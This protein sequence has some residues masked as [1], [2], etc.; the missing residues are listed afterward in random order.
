MKDW[1]ERSRA[2]SLT[3][4]EKRQFEEDGFLLLPNVVPQSRVAALVDVADRL[5]E[6]YRPQCGIG[7]NDIRPQGG[8]RPHDVLNLK[9]CATKDPAFL[10]LLDWPETFSKVWGILGWNIQL[11]HSQMVI[12]PP[13]P[14]DAPPIRNSPGWHQDSGL[15]NA[16]LETD[17]RPRI[18]V[19]V[20]FYLSDSSKPGR[21]N[22]MVVPGSHLKN[23]I[24]RPAEKG[25]HPKGAIEILAKPGS[26]VI[27]DRRLWHSGSVNASSITRK[28][29]FYGYSYRWLRPRSDLK[30][31]PELLNHCGPIRRQL[32]GVGC[33]NM[34]C[35]SPQD[36]DV[37]LRAWISE[38]A[39]VL[40]MA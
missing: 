32:L 2:A 3:E 28:M 34:S 35:T 22:F 19:K 9:D 20:G 30:I 39:P 13:Q 36:A 23:R 16:D 21:A 26:A 33:S 4:D 12:S 10:A 18:S 1:T 7:P 15:L 37:P 14:P 17:P 40:A 29:L 24:D 27:F 11:Y 8:L 5:E 25:K 31:T 38:H 6:T